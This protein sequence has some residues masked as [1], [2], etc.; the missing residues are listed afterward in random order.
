[1]VNSKE[2]LLEN[3]LSEL[4]K[5]SGIIGL[6]DDYRKILEKPAQT[7]STSFPVN[8]DD[9]TI[10]V[11]EGYRVQHNAARGPC[12]GGLRFSPEIDLDEIKAL[13]MLMTWKT[14][15][16]NIPYGGAKGGVVCDPWKL[17]LGELNRM[18]RRFSYSIMSVI[19]P[20][21]DIPAPD[22]N[23]NPTVMSWVMDTYSMLKGR[24]T[25]GVVTG[26]PLELGGS[27]GRTE[28]TG[29]GVYLT[30]E[31]ALRQKGTSCCNHVTIALQGFGNVGSNFARAAH[32]NGGRI[33]AVAD[34][35]GGVF[36][37]SGLNI[38][39][40]VEYAAQHSRRS[41]Q[42]YPEGD[43]IGNRELFELEVDV[44]APCAMENQ[45][46]LDNA[47]GIRASLVVEGANGPTTPAADDVLMD[48]GVTV[49]PDILANA[50]GVVVSYF[51]WVQGV[52]SFF[53]SEKQ[54]TDA[55]H[56]IL[57]RSFAEVNKTRETYSLQSLRV[58]AM[59]LA[60]QRVAKAI[61]LRG[62]FP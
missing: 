13:A 23:T 22:I 37:P 45:I 28:A 1:M 53:W 43:S 11:F 3:A 36:N 16:V 46:T 7:L 49:V 59:A 41:V 54:V 18:T 55:L 24:T 33:I 29:R 58:A 38:P 26:K 60:I 25:L 5:V 31:E 17:S 27:L 48:K 10:Q 35:Y 8:M 44:L 19:G 4:R 14:A 56:D 42:G 50:G 57:V 62:I 21:S 32:E 20:D 51:E 61:E 12:K 52:S 47:P 9:G 39:K 40:L 30:M 6:R 15:V 2:N 34:A